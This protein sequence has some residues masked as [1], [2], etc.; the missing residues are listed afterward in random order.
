MSPIRLRIGLPG[1]DDR[2]DSRRVAF[3]GRLFDIDRRDR[4]SNGKA[5]AVGLAYANVA[6]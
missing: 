2:H 1:S 3:R 5:R 4:L 6:T